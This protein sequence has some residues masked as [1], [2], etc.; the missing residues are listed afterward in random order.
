MS[1]RRGLL[2]SDSRS[3]VIGVRERIVK[4]DANMRKRIVCAIMN[5]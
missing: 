1:G 3:R 4:V 5:I 2:I